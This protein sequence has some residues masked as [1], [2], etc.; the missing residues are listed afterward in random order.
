MPYFKK[1]KKKG[2]KRVHYSYP[3]GLISLRWLLLRQQLALC[4]PA[5]FVQPLHLPVFYFEVARKT[6]KRPQTRNPRKV[7][8]SPLI[9]IPSQPGGTV[10]PPASSG[11]AGSRQPPGKRRGRCRDPAQPPRRGR[12]P[13]PRPR[14]LPRGTPRTPPAPQ[15][16]RTPSPRRVPARSGQRVVAVV[17]VMAVIIIK[18]DIQMGPCLRHQRVAER[19]SRIFPTEVSYPSALGQALISLQC[20]KRPG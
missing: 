6:R 4:P 7:S 13:P 16:P 18:G 11:A 3:K 5:E 15:S 8:F 17:L 10:P 20:N 12:R 1:R 2:K 14:S 9:A 19:L